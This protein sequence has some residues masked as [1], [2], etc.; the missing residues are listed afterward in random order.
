MRRKVIDI[1]TGI[2]SDTVV[3]PGDPKPVLESVSSIERDGYAVT[4]VCFGTH[5]G[6]HVDA[7]S[8]ILEDGS[9]IDEIPAGS[10]VGKAIVLDLSSAGS[11]IS[12]DDLEMAFGKFRGGCTPDVQVLLIKTRT[13]PDAGIKGVSLPV[14]RNLDADAGK[15]IMGQGFRTVGVDTLSVDVDPS[16]DNHRLFLRNGMVIVENLDLSGVDAGFYHFVCLPLKLYGCDAA[17]ARAILLER[18]SQI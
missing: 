7:P 10:F 5:T 14:E 16:L 6:T 8:H 2:S 17:P 11:D 9:S 4:R 13:S 12:C 1:S 15:W 18:R 3:Y